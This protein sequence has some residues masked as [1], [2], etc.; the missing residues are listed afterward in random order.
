MD[1][2]LIMKI[3]AKNICMSVLCALRLENPMLT[4]RR[5]ANVQ[6]TSRALLYGSAQL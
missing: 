3:M 4:L 6:K 2:I 5:I 1:N